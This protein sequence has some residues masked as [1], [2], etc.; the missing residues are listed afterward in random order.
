V[1][2]CGKSGAP[3]LPQILPLAQNTDPG[4][5]Q[6]ALRTLA[7]IGGPEALAAVKNALDDAGEAVQ[8]EAVS[9]L[10]NWPNTWPDDAGVAPPLLALAKS[11]KKTSHQIQAL[12]GYLLYVQ[13][14]KK[15][16]SQDKLAK[17][18][19]AAP[20]IKTPEAKRLVISV[21]GTVPAAGSLQRL[22]ALA[23]DDAVSEE[24]CLALV[25][26]ATD[27]NLK[28]ASQ[29]QRRGAL[30]AV[31]KKAKSEGTR[32]RAQDALQRLR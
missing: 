21:L 14:D 26:T 25:R 18:D 31:L 5:R 29:E 11:G 28:D 3:S 30:E 20:V 22:T 17:L 2:I 4:V 15:L 7:A 9:T 32:K 24:A 1:A 27:R 23:E 19:E 6:A 16:T 10:A 8:D 13:E 12:Q